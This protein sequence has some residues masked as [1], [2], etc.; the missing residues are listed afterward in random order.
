MNKIRIYRKRSKDPTYSC[1]IVAKLIMSALRQCRS[2]CAILSCS[3]NAI[4]GNYFTNSLSTIRIC[5]PNLQKNK[6]F[7]YSGPRDGEHWCLPPTHSLSLW[8]WHGEVITSKSIFSKLF[9]SIFTP[10]HRIAIENLRSFFPSNLKY[11]LLS[12]FFYL[13]I[14]SLDFTYIL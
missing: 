7:K 11:R 9:P 4:F 14:P 12:L 10:P 1:N 13:N 5:F 8:V 3:I 2:V 6:V